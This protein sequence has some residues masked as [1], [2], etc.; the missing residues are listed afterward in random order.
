MRDP[1][2][3]KYTR[4]PDDSGWLGVLLADSGQLGFLPE[5]TKVLPLR[6]GDGRVFFKVLSGNT[7]YVGKVA[8][9]QQANAAKYLVD[10]TLK[11]PATVQ[12]RYSGSPV[13]EVSPF[14]GKLK[15]QWA[16][17]SFGGEHARVTLNSEWSGKYTPIAP[18]AHLIMAPDRSHAN[19]STAG[20]RNAS[21]GL[22]CT[23]VWFPIQLEGKAGNSGR[24]IHAGHVS[25][26][27]VTAYEL[28]KWNALYDYLIASSV[29]GSDGR[30]IGN[31][32]VSQ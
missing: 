2:A 15:Q 27:C 32:V 26:G 11:G 23:D 24:Y 22:R 4:R 14:K 12:V 5:Y 25:E 28:T 29:P 19:I 17:A 21:A 3:A 1:Q 8:S 7:E 9:L 31:L 30:Y 16:T 6:E 10:A 20:Y 13:E 18:G